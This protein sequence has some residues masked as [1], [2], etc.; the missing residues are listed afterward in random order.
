M[1]LRILKDGIYNNTIHRAGK[2][3]AGDELETDV[4][5][6]QSLIASGYAEATNQRISESVK[7]LEVDVAPT[8]KRARK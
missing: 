8:S 7:P 3:K 4:T 2:Y 5:Y 1:K 6:G